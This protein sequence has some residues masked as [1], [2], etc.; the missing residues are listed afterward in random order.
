MSKKGIEP[1]L[2]NAIQEQTTVRK[3]S[4]GLSSV[5]CLRLGYQ[6]INPVNSVTIDACKNS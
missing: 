4:R 5:Y 2:P 6:R 3:P 1:A